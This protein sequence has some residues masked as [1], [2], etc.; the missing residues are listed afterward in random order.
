MKNFL[1]GCFVGVCL[2]IIIDKVILGGELSVYEFIIGIID[3]PFIQ[4]HGI[5]I[6]AGLALYFLTYKMADSLTQK[7]YQQSQDTL[8][9]N[10]K[11]LGKIIKSN[12]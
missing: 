2:T 5:C 12:K 3:K 11:L 9:E 6:L 8:K 7:F 10:T 1:S 4:T